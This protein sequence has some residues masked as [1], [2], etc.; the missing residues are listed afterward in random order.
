MKLAAKQIDAYNESAGVVRDRIRGYSGKQPGDPQ[1][2]AEAIVSLIAMPQPPLRLP[3]GR[4]A[5]GGIRAKLAQVTEDVNRT[6][7]IAVATDFPKDSKL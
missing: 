4:V 2:G 1:R 5:V 7:A 3:L 6:E